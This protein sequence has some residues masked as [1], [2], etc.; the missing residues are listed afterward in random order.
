M[1]GNLVEK[2]IVTKYI[3]KVNSR[4]Y[5]LCLEDNNRL[6]ILPEQFKELE[7]LFVNLTKEIVNIFKPHDKWPS[8]KHHLSDPKTNPINWPTPS[9]SGLPIMR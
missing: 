7:K 9:S 4:S 1:I 3:V 6:V 2:D 5:K 8:L